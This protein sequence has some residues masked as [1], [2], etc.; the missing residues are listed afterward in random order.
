MRCAYS[1]IVI[2]LYKFDKIKYNLI[3]NICLLFVDRV[4]NKI[5]I[6]NPLKER[7]TYTQTN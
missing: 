2:L 7:T 5:D 4:W 1:I 6:L 3:F